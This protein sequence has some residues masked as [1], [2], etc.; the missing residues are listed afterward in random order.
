MPNDRPIQRIGDVNDYGAPI[1]DSDGNTTV[2]ANNILVSVNTSDV[3]S[4]LPTQSGLAHINVHTAN[5]SSS[6]FAHNIS[7]NFTDNAD[8]CG[9]VR[10]GGSTNVFV[11]N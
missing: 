8:T 4:H 5:G 6:V 11:G 9:H 7:I 10:I 3:V 1:S 2:Y